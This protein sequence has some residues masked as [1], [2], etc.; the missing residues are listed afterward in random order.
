MFKSCMSL[1]L[2]LSFEICLFRL[3]C[4]KNYLVLSDVCSQKPH[5]VQTFSFISGVSK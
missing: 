1:R 5:Y 3:S 4:N 2:S